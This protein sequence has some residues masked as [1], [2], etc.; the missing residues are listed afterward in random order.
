M[1]ER[2]A[3][4]ET[5]TAEYRTWSNM[6][7]RCSNPKCAEYHFYGGRGIAVCDEWKISYNAFLRDMGR[8]PSQKHSIDRIDFNGPYAPQNCRWA[9]QKEQCRNKRDSRLITHDGVTQPLAAWAEGAGMSTGT[10]WARLKLGWDMGRAL[11]RRVTPA[12]IENE[13]RRN[14][15]LSVDDVRAIRASTARTIDLVRQYGVHKSTITEVRK[16]ASRSNVQ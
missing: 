9:T 1:R 12:P 11:S 5:L 4:G 14:F 10:L 7:N 3:K 8:R 15:K 6:K 13:R 2:H 16:G